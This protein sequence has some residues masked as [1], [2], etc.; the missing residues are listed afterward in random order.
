MVSWQSKKQ[1][2]VALST[3]EAEYLTLSRAAQETMWLRRLNLD[4]GN[5]QDGPTVINEDNQSAISVS[6]NAQ[7]HGRAK[8]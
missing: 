1:D 2:T 8:H 6:R 4:Q 3:A 7:F 5:V